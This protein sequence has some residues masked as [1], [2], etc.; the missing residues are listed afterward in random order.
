MSQSVVVVTKTE[1]VTK[2]ATPPSATSTPTATSAVV[3]LTPTTTAATAPEWM[4]P[5]SYEDRAL[6]IITKTSVVV[7]ALGAAIASLIVT[8]NSVPQ[9]RD[10]VKKMLNP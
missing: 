9:L 7:T 10:Y 3:E 8:I 6:E 4:Q 5:S 1:T 2:V